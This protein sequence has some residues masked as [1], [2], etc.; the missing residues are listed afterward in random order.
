VRT[1]IDLLA[2][3][4]NTQP[5]QLELCNESIAWCVAEKRTFLRQRI[6][7]RLAAL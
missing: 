5:Q 7:A 3:I 4:P 1:V 6:Q 2:K